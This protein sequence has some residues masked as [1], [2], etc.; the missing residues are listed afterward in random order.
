MSRHRY[1]QS[2]SISD[3][4]K[5]A[6][7]GWGISLHRICSRTGSFPPSL[8]YY[9]IMKYSKA[10]DIIL[11]PFSGKG[12]APLE[13]CL[14][15]RVGMGNDL[16]PEAYVLTRAKVRPVRYRKVLEWIEWAKNKIMPIE[17]RVCDVEENVRVF[18]S[19]YTL[20][21]ILAVRDL[22]DDMEDNDLSN[23]IKALMLGILHGPSRMH[24]SIKSS[25]SFSMSPNY[26]K[27][28]MKENGVRKPRRDVLKCLKMKADRVF[29][30]GIPAVRGEAFI[31]DA[32]NL[33][34]EDESVDLV[35]TSPPYFN[36]QT[37]AW[38]NW[39]RLWFLGYRYEEVREKLFQTN[40]LNKFKTF[41]KECLREI[42][43]V[44]RWDRAA[45]IVLGTVKLRDN[46]VNMAEEVAPIAEEVGFNIE[47]FISDGVPKSNKYLW[48]LND[49]QGVNREVI[50]VMTKGEFIP[51]DLRIDWSNAKP[52]SLI[53]ELE[54]V[55]IV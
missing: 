52:T 29:R 5:Y 31:V 21:Q 22:L 47:F 35:I 25:H 42:F 2:Y 17:Y 36:M 30:D 27:H 55:V 26:V 15:N 6:E 14:N 9:F 12:T 54:E 53:R 28:Y 46:I 10:G 1:I 44:L 11:D 45:V 24:L 41:I 34:I 48:Y 32:R 4:W 38:D 50:L 8:A 49:E 16:A 39:L 7:N 18:Y 51:N 3:S 23:F 43:R 19:D 40:S 20:R 13:A 37:Y 33:P